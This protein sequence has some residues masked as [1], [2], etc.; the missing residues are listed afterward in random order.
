MIRGPPRAPTDGANRGDCAAT[1]LT[2]TVL[3]V[4]VNVPTV[5]VTGFRL[6]RPAAPGAVP[7][8]R[9]A[10]PGAQ[11]LHPHRGMTAGAA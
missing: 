6:P 10:T 8:V 1:V 7:L 3:T 5:T 9:R 11:L 2:A 4:T